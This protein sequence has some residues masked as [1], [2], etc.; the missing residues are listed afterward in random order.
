M[1]RNC[2]NKS[3]KTGNTE[4][5]YATF[6]NGPKNLVVLP[7]LSDGLATVK[8]KAF[9]SKW[10]YETFDANDPV[11]TNNQGGGTVTFSYKPLGTEDDAYTSAKP[12][13]A[14]NYVVK[15]E[16]IQ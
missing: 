9:I 7:G 5:Y 2:K 16:L 11:I 1:S 6:G 13:K 15:A 8:G 12:K 3:V 14:G 10:A 4:M